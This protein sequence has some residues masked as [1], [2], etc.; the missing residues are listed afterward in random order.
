MNINSVNNLVS[1]GKQPVMK[2]TVKD[3][4]TKKVMPATLYKMDPSKSSDLFEVEK[5][6]NTRDIT[7]HFK[8]DNALGLNFRNYYLLKND[9]TQEVVGCAET[10]NHYSP[11]NN[12]AGGFVMLVGELSE[13]K[14]Y[15]NG[16]EPILT[17]LMNEARK[18]GQNAIVTCSDENV[19]PNMKQ[20]KPVQLN[21]GEYYI[22]ASR[23][24]NA[25]THGEKRYNIS[26]EV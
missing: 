18:S 23:F 7:F 25:L 8:R 22:P 13:N 1:F 11:R 16:K 17:F 3:V 12:G 5:S 21:T 20:L 24:D 4:E 2:C 14:K 26:Y 9:K 19:A 6:K 10:E 15:L